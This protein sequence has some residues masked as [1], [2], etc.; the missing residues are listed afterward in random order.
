MQRTLRLLSCAKLKTLKMQHHNLDPKSFPASDQNV[1]L[2]DKK[3]RDLMVNK[4][5]LVEVPYTASLAH[6]MNA[7]VANGVVAMPVAAPPGHWIG[8]GG[9]MIMESDKQTG[10]VRKHYIGMV[11]MLD[12]LAHIAGDDQINGGDDASHLDDKMSVP[13]SSI[14]GH[15][16]EGLSL[17]TLNPNTSILECMEMLSKGI[18]RALVPIDSQMENVSGAELVESSSSYQML[19]QMDLLK[20]LKEHADELQSILSGTV[21]EMGAVSDH[22]YGV[23]GRTRLIDTI[24]CM[25][26]A[27]LNA[28][29]IV[30]ASNYLEENSNQLINAKG[31][32]LLGTFSA[33]D[34]RGCH[35]S[36]LNTWLPLTVLEFTETVWSSPVYASANVSEKREQVSC[37][38]DSTLQEVI[39]KAVTKHVHRVWVVDEEGLLV[40]LVSLSDIIRVVR[41]SLLLHSNV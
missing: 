26:A 38:L 41:A 5:R 19:T 1:R 6:T 37:H 25:K 4:R 18:H 24:K 40:G 17:W 7:L 10:V 31:R 28:V 15:C 39:D 32:K 13:V 12:I 23:T 33:T 11:T 9:S 2:R 20:F 21:S 16:L 8:A 34:L 22:V 30:L 3:V 29:P 27:L 14:I 36:T 35:L